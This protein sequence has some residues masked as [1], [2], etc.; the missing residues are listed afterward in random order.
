MIKIEAK[1]GT[2]VPFAESEGSMREE[3]D[4]PCGLTHEGNN[5]S[6]RLAEY[7]ERSRKRSQLPKEISLG[8]T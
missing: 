6:Q 4:Q 8:E 5:G 2:K 7:S 3:G 1:R